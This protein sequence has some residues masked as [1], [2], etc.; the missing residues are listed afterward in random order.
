MTVTGHWI[1]AA[2]LLGMPIAVE[3]QVRWTITAT[4]ELLE[5][6]QPPRKEVREAGAK[7]GAR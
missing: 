3:A 7:A 6:L 1:A 2:L 4:V 5:R